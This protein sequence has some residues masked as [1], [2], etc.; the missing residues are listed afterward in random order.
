L[1]SFNSVFA[2]TGITKKV[3]HT[4]LV[5]ESDP[6]VELCGQQTC[7]PFNGIIS[8]PNYITGSSGITYDIIYYYSG[9]NG[10]I[11]SPSLPITLDPNNVM[12]IPSW[13]VSLSGLGDFCFTWR[14]IGN[15]DFDHPVDFATQDCCIKLLNCNCEPRIYTYDADVCIGTVKQFEIDIP[16]GCEHCISSESIIWTDNGVN[17]TDANQP[18]KITEN[19]N[20]IG[21]HHICVTYLNTCN[22]HIDGQPGGNTLGTSKLYCWDINVKE[23]GCECVHPFTIN[24]VVSTYYP[25]EHIIKGAFSMET[26]GVA[27]Q[28]VRMDIVYFNFPWQHTAVNQSGYSFGNFTDLENLPTYTQFFLPSNNVAKGSLLYGDVQLINQFSREYNYVINPAEPLNPSAFM[29]YVIT[30]PDLLHDKND[31]VYCIRVTLTY[32][33]CT[34]CNCL[35]VYDKKGLFSGCQGTGA[36]QLPERKRNIPKGSTTILEQN[37]LV[38]PNPNN[39]NCTV[40]FTN[41]NEAKQII[42]LDLNG[43]VLQNNAVAANINSFTINNLATGLYFVKVVSGNFTQTQKII[44]SNQ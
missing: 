4:S 29:N 9:P 31:W 28:S 16:N 39:G 42:I 25:Q 24:P 30:T 11:T 22:E 38:A 3:T 33:D 18:E 15:N 32:D 10:S 13:N 27:V 34:T 35:L 6:T 17:I 2:Q 14:I 23:C 5:S 20:T 44:V 36:T 19:F 26:F 7:S 43:K 1:L 12:Q 37:F 41:I 21:N 8:C 40:S